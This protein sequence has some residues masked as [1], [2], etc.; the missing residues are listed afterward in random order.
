MIN[1]IVKH[2]Y[3]SNLREDSQ[4]FLSLSRWLEIK[5]LIL[6][7]YHADNGDE[8]KIKEEVEDLEEFIRK[9]NGP[10]S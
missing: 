5:K 1:K 4:R 9:V 8:V 2:L 7:Y 3:R 6:A 10:V